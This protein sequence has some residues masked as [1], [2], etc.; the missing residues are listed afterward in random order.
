MSADSKHVRKI[1]ALLPLL[2]ILLAFKRG[3]TE[4]WKVLFFSLEDLKKSCPS[5]IFLTCMPTSRRA[6][7]KRQMTRKVPS[8]TTT[9]GATVSG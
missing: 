6:L 2:G 1:I 3:G 9:G 7:G 8:S 4:D 5:P